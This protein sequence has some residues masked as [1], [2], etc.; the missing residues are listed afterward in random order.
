MD[1]DTGKINPLN[2]IKQSSS[3]GHITAADVEN[4]D[5]HTQVQAL[6]P[7]TKHANKAVDTMTMTELLVARNQCFIK[8]RFVD[9]GNGRAHG[10]NVEFT[11]FSRVY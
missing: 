8:T 9:L 11:Q 1:V 4:P 2:L 10:A 6:D 3:K 7:I 5:R